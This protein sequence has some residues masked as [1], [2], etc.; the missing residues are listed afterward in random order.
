MSVIFSLLQQATLDTNP[1]PPAQ[2]TLK[3][4]FTE[5]QPG[6]PPPPYYPSHDPPPHV[7]FPRQVDTAT[8]T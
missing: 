2:D 7:Q 3:P 8:K 6:P 1:P 4:D 5:Y